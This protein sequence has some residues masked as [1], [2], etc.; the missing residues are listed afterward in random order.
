[1]NVSEAE[2]FGGLWH[3][4]MNEGLSTSDRFGTE[5]DASSTFYRGFDEELNLR[6]SSIR[7]AELFEPFLQYANFEVGITGAAY[8]TL[9]LDDL[10]RHA[11]LAADIVLETDRL[12]AMPA[13]SEEITRFLRDN[14]TS[15]TDTL[16]FTLQSVL[17]RGITTDG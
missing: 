17:I 4:S 10:R 13:T 6:Q 2:T 7:R 12:A 16:A 15:M 9:E 11:E 5:F 8:T 3:V 14:R 1:M